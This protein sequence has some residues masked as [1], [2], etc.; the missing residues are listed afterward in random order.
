MA[1][2]QV[3]LASVVEDVLQQHGTRLSDRGLA[4]RKAEEACMTNHSLEVFL[5]SFVK[6]KLTEIHSSS[7]FHKQRGFLFGFDF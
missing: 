7:F 4:S 3:L 2:E 6:N 1:T 5:L